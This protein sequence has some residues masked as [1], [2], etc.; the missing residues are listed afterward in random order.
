MEPGSPKTKL[1]SVLLF[2]ALLAGMLAV[3]T[4]GSTAGAQTGARATDTPVQSTPAVENTPGVP[5]TSAPAGTVEATATSSI[6][7]NTPGPTFT[8]FPTAA[9]T[10]T[11]IP[12]SQA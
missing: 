9:A 12:A 4:M 10:A 11:T 3:L 8:P 5:P 2:G 1:R 7:E 6:P